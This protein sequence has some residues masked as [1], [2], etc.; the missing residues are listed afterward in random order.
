[1][2]NIENQKTT[3]TAQPRGESLSTQGNDT[4]QVPLGGEKRTESGVPLEGEKRTESGVPL[5]G[6]KRTESGVP[7]EGEKRTESGVPLEGEKRTESGVPLEGEKRTESGVPLEGE[8][9][10]E[11][12]V[13]LVGEK[14]SESGV[15]LV[16]EEDVTALIEAGRD[17]GVAVEMAVVL[18]FLREKPFHLPGAATHPPA[19]R[20][21][22]THPRGSAFLRLALFRNWMRVAEEDKVTWCKSRLVLNDVFKNVRDFLLLNVHDH[23]GTNSTSL[24]PQGQLTPTDA[25]HSNCA[26]NSSSSTCD[27]VALR[28]GNDEPRSV[29]SRT[30]VMESELL[31]ARDSEEAQAVVMEAL[32]AHVPQGLYVFTGST[33]VGYQSLSTQLA[34]HRVK[35][36]AP[37]HAQGAPPQHALLFQITDQARDVRNCVLY[38]S[39]DTV[40]KFI[41][42]SHEK[43]KLLKLENSTKGAYVDKTIVN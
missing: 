11:S 42:N 26:S 10:T 23:Q 16:R 15:P 13:P 24:T 7:L 38:P 20:T 25:K 36:P 4:Q 31:F 14:R 34:P 21:T 5:E 41:R 12:G 30:A 37:D 33:H 40:E 17:R 22:G 39:C 32:L 18:G 2:E 43:E 1:M 3:E 9:R 35:L 27:S 28:S 6:E 8:K 29:D 19:T